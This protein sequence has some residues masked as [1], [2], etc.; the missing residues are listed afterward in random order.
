MLIQYDLLLKSLENILEDNV[1]CE[2]GELYLSNKIK[3]M[4]YDLV[5]EIDKKFIEKLH[6]KLEYKDVQ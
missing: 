2:D 5:K 1:R 6:K 3:Y 4:L